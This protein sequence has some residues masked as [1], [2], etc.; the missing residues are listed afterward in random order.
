MGGDVR[1]EQILDL[2]SNA[3]QETFYKECQ[4]T[5]AGAG[6]CYEDE[7]NMSPALIGLGK[8]HR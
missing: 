8:E 1:T 4:G 2:T 7:T 5:P 6:E 3:F